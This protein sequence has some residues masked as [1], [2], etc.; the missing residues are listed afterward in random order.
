MSLKLY[1]GNGHRV[2]KSGKGRNDVRDDYYDYDPRCDSRNGY[3]AR[4]DDRNA[5]YDAR[6]DNRNAPQNTSRN[7]MCLQFLLHCSHREL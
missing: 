2:N 6:Y 1:G 5:R 3:D 4:Y 7:G